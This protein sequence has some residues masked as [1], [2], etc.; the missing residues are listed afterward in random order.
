MGCL[1][2]AAM[3]TYCALEGPVQPR[4]PRVVLPWTERGACDMPAV[5]MPFSCCPLNYSP[6]TRKWHGSCW[7]AWS[8]KGNGAALG[9]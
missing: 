5:T 6:K 4:S 8:Q 3:V 7:V 1:V 9:R 2:F